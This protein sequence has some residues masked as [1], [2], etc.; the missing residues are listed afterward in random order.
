MRHLSR[1]HTDILQWTFCYFKDSRTSSTVDM[2][3]C[4]HLYTH[5]LNMKRL[6][7]ET[8]RPSFGKILNQKLPHRI[9]NYLG[10]WLLKGDSGA[11]DERWVSEQMGGGGGKSVTTAGLVMQD[12]WEADVNCVLQ[13]L[14]LRVLSPNKITHRP[15]LNPSISP[16]IHM[17]NVLKHYSQ[18][19]PCFK[20]T[21]EQLEG[22][23]S[24]DI[25]W[26]LTEQ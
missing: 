1:K 18:G 8:N 3:N 12:S 11:V 9:L 21:V 2:L 16:S 17:R 5:S 6:E 4:T 7:L 22:I 23:V 19:R 26:N 14:Q 20:V 10:M 13:C 15:F 25:K 24:Q